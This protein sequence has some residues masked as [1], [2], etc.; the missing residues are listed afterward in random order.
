MITTNLENGVFIYPFTDLCLYKDR[1]LAYKSDAAHETRLRHS[2]E[3]NALCD[4]HIDVLVR[5]LYAQPTIGLKEAEDLWAQPIPKTTFKA[6]WLL[7]RPGA[8]VYVHEHGKLNAYV[9]E[10]VEGGTEWSDVYRRP[11]P[12]EVK[13]WNL[14]YDGRYLTR[15]VKLIN[16]LVFDGEREIRS[17]PLYPTRFAEDPVTLHRNLVARGERFVRIMKKPTLQEFTGPSTLQG[18]RTFSRARVVVDH[19]CQPW[20]LD[21][22]K[23]QAQDKPGNRI[24]CESPEPRQT[25]SLRTKFD[26]YDNLDLQ[27]SKAI[28][29]HHYFLC[30]S[31]VY[32]FVLRDRAWD[33][34][35][36]AL[37]EDPIHNKNVIDTLVM[38]PESNKQM[39]RAI[40]EVFG[41]TSV[42]SP[43]TADF[44]KGKGEGQIILLHGPPGTGKTLTAESVAEYTARP[45]L[46]I[47]AADLGHEP[48]MLE[49][50]LLNFFRD[51]NRWNA[52]VL[53][54]EAD[55]Y[56][57]RRSQFDL[58]RNSIVSI[59]LRVLDYFQ[60]ILFL[61]TNRVGHFDEAFR[62]R[63]HVQ[64]G[65]DP[66]N[67]AARERI[68]ENHFRKLEDN[69]KNGGQE[70]ICSYS[71]QEYIRESRRLQE[72]RWNGR[73][74]RNAFQT[75]VALACFEAK[76]RNEPVPKLSDR[77]L[78]QVVTMSRNFKAYMQ[79]T[80]RHDES[81]VAFLEGS[82]DDR[83]TASGEMS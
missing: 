27:S 79:A 36:V 17:L 72:L 81:Q 58:R 62:S 12:Y 6:L 71:A 57:E 46:S 82:R 32:A 65:Y 1:L 24:V 78:V 11:Q 8:E 70:I 31:H 18:A 15:T 55:V 63:I 43:F 77:H 75:A 13:V 35:D 52:I 53:L 64:I 83:Q 5:Y 61:T 25:T 3:Y 42:H 29:E 66:L 30:Y 54:D 48:E 34:L 26:D 67:D 73:E 9:V 20:E 59:F 74:I 16:I 44:I 10:S 19:T 7:F 23:A 80:E 33:L 76:Q 69:A 21:E 37:M 45:L 28:T 40:C 14:N 50:K 68:W 2:P 39:I 41:G 38:K 22:T 49:R 4:K 56:L 60:G 51:G 47:T